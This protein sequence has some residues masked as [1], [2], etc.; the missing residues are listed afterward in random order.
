MRLA[1][2]SRKEKIL[3]VMPSYHPRM[4]WLERSVESVMYQTYDNFEC[5]IVKDGCKHA[6]NNFSCLECE[7]CRASSSFLKSISDKR[8]SFYR[9][10][11]NMGAAGWGPRNFAI[12]NSSHELICYL[13]DDNWY[14]S[15]HLEKLYAAI[16]DRDSDMA[17]TGTR[18]WSRDMQ[19]V[20]ERVHPYAPKQGHIDTSEIMHRR[21]LI[22]IFG[23]WRK[24]PKCNDWDIVSRWRNVRWSHTNSITLNFYLREGCGIHRE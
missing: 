2:T 24:V 3:V 14:E 8:F 17:Y 10:P 16:S 4:E 5:M 13:D 19:V 12:L 6:D 22:D 9:L 18:I 21:K 1:D 15:V 7:N 23:G 20:S 11:S